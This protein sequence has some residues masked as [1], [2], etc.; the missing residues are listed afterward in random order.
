MS[1]DKMDTLHKK[2]EVQQKL[3]REEERRLAEIR[4][5]SK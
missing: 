3:K 4:R 2:Y 5:I 1:Q